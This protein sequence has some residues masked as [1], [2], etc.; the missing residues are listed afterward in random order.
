ML[1]L[2]VSSIRALL[3]V[4]V[5]PVALIMPAET[6]PG[7]EIILVAV[8]PKALTTPVNLAALALTSPLT[9]RSTLGSPAGRSLSHLPIF[10][11]PLIKSDP[12]NLWVLSDPLPNILLPESTLFWAS[13]IVNPSI[14]KLAASRKSVTN[15][16]DAVMLLLALIM[17]EDIILISAN[18]AVR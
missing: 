7:V 10:T 11:L 9:L 6:V 3:A 15:K 4:I 12:V 2:S 13:I 18:E 5:P 1:T 17:L 8:K 16:L 14:L